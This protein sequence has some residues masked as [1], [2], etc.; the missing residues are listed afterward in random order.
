MSIEAEGKVINDATEETKLGN[1]S[2]RKGLTM[3]LTS[4]IFA[5]LAGTF[6][7]FAMTQS[8]TVWMCEVLSE[9]F[10]GYLPSHN[11]IFCSQVSREIQWKTTFTKMRC[12]GK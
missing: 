7:K 1:T 6:G 11:Y 2:P 8:E 4:G 9:S 10:S 3:A 12:G 5:S